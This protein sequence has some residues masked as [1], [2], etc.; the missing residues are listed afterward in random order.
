[1][2]QTILHLF[3]EQFCENERLLVESNGLSASTFRFSTG[4]CALRLKNERGEAVLLPFQGQQIW[5]AQF[6]G[7][8]LGMTSYFPEPR[9]T[10]NYLETYGAFLLHCGVSAMGVPTAQ[11]THP[12]HGE[13]PNATYQQAWLVLGEDEQGEYI[14]LGGRYQHIV[15]F[16]YNYLAEPLV[17]L[18]RGGSLLHVHFSLENLRHAP[19]EWM[20]LAHI[21]F[22]PV[23]YGRMVYSALPTPQHVRVRQSIPSHIRPGPGYVEFL[24]TLKEH[25]EQHHLFTPQQVYDPE[26]VFAIDYLHDNH[27]YAHSMQVHPDGS[28]DY[29]RHSPAVLDH[30]IR[31][32]VRTPD[33]QALGFAMPGT[34]EP[35]GYTAE[36]AKGN[37][38]TLPGKSKVS[39]DIVAGRL[40][41][42]E[43]QQME[44]QIEKIVAAA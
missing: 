9:P 24:Q 36:K 26:V 13:L 44:A 34:A 21:N 38:K 43:A 25:P 18:Y 8:P 14:G 32:I 4:V 11:D 30:C 28:A 7:R 3:P 16:S 20:Y 39:F 40:E 35:E 1:M 37:L 12:L 5:S 22:R 23:D 27:G 2:N 19:L 15:A 29:V 42:G 33:Q 6:G 10:R 17:K 31:W 41:P